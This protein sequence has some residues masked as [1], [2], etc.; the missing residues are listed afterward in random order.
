MRVDAQW[1]IARTKGLTLQHSKKLNNITFFYFY[2]FAPKKYPTLSFRY[3]KNLMSLIIQTLT[4]FHSIHFQIT[5]FSDTTKSHHTA[6][7]ITNSLSSIYDILEERE[8]ERGREEKNAIRVDST[9]QAKMRP[10]SESY[11]QPLRVLCSVDQL[12]KSLRLN[13]LIHTE[14]DMLML[15]LYKFCFGYQLLNI[16]QIKDI[17]FN[18]PPFLNHNRPK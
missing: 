8:R 13:S 9:V 12:V 16:K 7:I 4:V 10:S 2:T 18:S 17:T 15:M 5:T 11:G 14:R 3:H 1:Q 6:T